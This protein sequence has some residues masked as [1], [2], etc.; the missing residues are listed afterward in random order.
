MDL[1]LTDG[2]LSN[3]VNRWRNEI[4]IQGDFYDS[5]TC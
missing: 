3:I 1:L 2:K 5:I 4:L